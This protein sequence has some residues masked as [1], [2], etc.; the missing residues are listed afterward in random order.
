M[1]FVKEKMLR[2]LE[3]VCYYIDQLQFQV[4]MPPLFS[5]SGANQAHRIDLTG[6]ELG[7]TT[8]RR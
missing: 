3:S 7:W 6:L 2:K 1:V 5:K 4:S 8:I